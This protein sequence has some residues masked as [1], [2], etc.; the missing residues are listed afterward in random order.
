MPAESGRGGE[1]KIED[2]SAWQSDDLGVHTVAT[3]ICRSRMD[4]TSRSFSVLPPSPSRS[5]S[6]LTVSAPVLF[7]RAL[8]RALCTPARAASMPSPRAFLFK[9]R[10]QGP[11]SSEQ[12]P[13]RTRARA[14]ACGRQ[15][16]ALTGQGA[17][18]HSESVVGDRERIRRGAQPEER[19]N[20]P[21][22]VCHGNGLPCD[23]FLFF[24]RQHL[25]ALFRASRC[26]LGRCRR[27]IQPARAPAR[28]AP[29]SPVPGPGAA[30]PHD[31]QC[32]KSSLKRR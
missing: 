9:G 18:K 22:R 13:P 10:L 26:V 8:P 30:R 1:E 25:D 11:V 3:F 15:K 27:G 12:S 5:N 32:R 6:T 4:K 23:R 2:S 7:F 31:D 28:V 24:W 14:G 16:P 21:V 19:C 29:G 17:G 20:T